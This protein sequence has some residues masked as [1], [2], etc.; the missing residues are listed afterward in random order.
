[1]E[2]GKLHEI[3]KKEWGKIREDFYYPQLPPPRLTK[4]IANGRFSFNNL[5]I[6]INPDY[7]KKLAQEGCEEKVILNAMLGHEVGHFADYPG[8]ILNLLKLHKVARESLNKQ[9]AQ[10]ARG[11]FTN[12]Q[13]NLNL[14]ANR[15]YNTLIPSLRATSKEVEGLEKL[16]FGIYQ[17][18]WNQD[19]EIKLNFKEKCLIR[20]LSKLNYLNKEKQEQNLRKFIKNTREYLEDLEGQEEGGNGEG[21]I[22]EGADPN[23]ASIF[24]E[25]QIREGVKQFARESQPGKFEKTVKEVLGAG[26]EKGNLII[27]GNFYSALA[28]NYSIPIRQRKMR[29]NGGLY[30]YSHKEFSMGDTIDDLD[31]FSSPGILP[32]VTQKWVKKQGEVMEEN[33]G[34]PN[35]LIVIDSSESMINPDENISASVLGGTVIANAYIDNNSSVAVYNFSASDIVLKPS[36]NKEKI[37]QKIRTYQNGGT[38]FNP[39]IIE[40]IIRNEEYMDISVISD[41]VINNL[42]EFHNYVSKIP[43]LHRVHLFYTNPHGY[44]DI[45]A[46]LI[47]KENVGI[48]PLWSASHIRDITMGEL[49]KS[50]K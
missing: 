17:K 32:G 40:K 30:P 18:L 25:N 11:T 3:M 50:I 20:K 5:Q 31:C 13:N 10:V 12:I 8:S 23:L 43:N 15:G 29:K 28:E 47:S 41:M 27:A 37:H 9:Q 42:E 6:D 14:L 21:G 48:L 39:S 44:S 49:R 36:R 34:T 19:L 26:T 4:E 7:V 46:S 2:S 45:P 16:A 33:F 38:T 1:M 35:S 22:R 24:S